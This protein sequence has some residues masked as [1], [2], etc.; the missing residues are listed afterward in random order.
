MN[1]VTEIPTEVAVVEDL[2]ALFRVHYGRLVRALALVCG[3][4]ERAADAVQEAF[5]KAHLRWRRL[6][7]YDDPIGWVRRDAIN[8]LRDERRR[9][10]RKRAAL[11]RLSR[12]EPAE[13]A[14]ATARDEELM[15]LL[16]Q[17][18]RQPRV[19]GALLYVVLLPVDEVAEAL[20]LSDGA[21]K[22]HLHQGR[23]RLR[24]QM[25]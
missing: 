16:D 5:V 3:D 12:T 14:V 8:R 2:D 20:D 9:D 10:V 18:P 4:R 19:C 6:Q 23:E 17:L 13:D 1:D 7:R 22:Y 25:T 15:R 21:V 24:E 11:E